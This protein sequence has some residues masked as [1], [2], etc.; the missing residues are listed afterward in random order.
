MGPSKNRPYIRKGLT[1]VDLTSGLRCTANPVVVKVNLYLLLF[2]SKTT[3]RPHASA[4]F[5]EKEQNRATDA[6]EHER[7]R[8]ECLLK[9]LVTAS[10]VW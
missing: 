6:A 10:A 1:S 5:Q 9:S 3:D 8:K 4:V 7:M 2:L